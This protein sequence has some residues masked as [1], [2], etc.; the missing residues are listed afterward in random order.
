M[1]YK[2]DMICII[3]TKG[4]IFSDKERLNPDNWPEKVKNG[5]EEEKET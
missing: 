2:N 3:T 4:V 5:S 1:K